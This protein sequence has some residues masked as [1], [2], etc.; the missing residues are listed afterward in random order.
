MFSAPEQFIPADYG[1]AWQYNLTE[2]AGPGAQ[3]SDGSDHEAAKLT[4]AV[5]YRVGGTRELDG[6][7]VF[8]FE[9]YRGGRIINTDLLTVNEHG[10]QCWGRV[11]DA[12]QITRFDPPQAIVASPMKVGATWD[13]ET[14]SGDD[15]VHQHYQIVDQTS[16]TVPAGTFRA[17]HIRGQQDQPVRM[18][19]ERWFVPKIGIVKDITETKKETGELLRRISLELS[20]LPKVTSRPELK[21]QP[22]RSKLAV[23]VSNEAVGENRNTFVT[24][25]PKIYARWRGQG[26]RAQSKIRVSWIAEEVEGVA[27]P[28]YTID[29]ATAIATDKDSHGTFTLARPENGWTPGI[30]RVEFYLDGTFT[31]A[32]KLKIEKSE[33]AKF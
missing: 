30:Y 23:S 21:N 28:D 4:A 27:P 26:L 29:E 1:T 31:D 13:F 9:M 18:S 8:E 20:G 12:G 5:V 25:T 7:E 16:V 11:D 17:Y 32:V 14:G 6:R 15:K 19:I 24:T 10:I 3:L 2:E 22:G 33:A